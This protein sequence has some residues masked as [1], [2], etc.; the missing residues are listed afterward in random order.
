MWGKV[1]GDVF[2]QV[3]DGL[4]KSNLKWMILRNYEGLPYENRSKDVDI[5][6]PKKNFKIA[7]KIIDEVLKKNGFNKKILT[8]YPYAWCTTY[9][10]VEDDSTQSI[11]IDIV[12]GFIWKGVQIFSA[13]GL[14]ANSEVY[15]DFRIPNKVDD[16]IGLFIKPYLTGAFIKD[17]YKED[18]INI[19][20]NN[21]IEFMEQMLCILD[22]S[23]ILEII[24]L[25]KNGEIE[26]TLEIRKSV[27]TNILRRSLIN[28]P[29]KTS[30][31]CITH[32]TQELYRRRKIAK[33]SLIC[34][35]GPD[36][37]GK[38]TF[39]ELL[40]KKSVEIFNK[41]LDGIKVYHFR[42]NIIPNLGK[43]MENIG[44]GK[45]DTNFENPHRGTPKGFISSFIRIIYYWIDYVIGYWA[46]I[47]KKC[48]I[49]YKIIFD[50]YF[51]DFI[52]DP[53]RSSIKLPLWIRMILLNVT[54]QP[55]IV[56]ILSCNEDIIYK[57]KQELSIKKIRILLNRYN[58]LAKT[59]NRFVT[60][61]AT[62]TPSGLTNEALKIWIERSSTDNE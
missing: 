11:T 30:F 6:I 50:R 12:D 37:V 58:N 16:A 34:V 5:L 52:V 13:D 27:C 60:L 39:I 14:Y 38:S 55:S 9:F 61:D 36:G 2:Q 49:G 1:Q 53:E 43:T 10:R 57:R 18:I 23:I 47:R 19:V 35:L 40:H 54:P 31:N 48:N 3:I 15:R 17:K 59:S 8:K 41:E 32:Y 20:N 33:G 24:Q 25:I 51:Y 22:K 26:K 45:Q 21:E 44:V 56:F 4:N 62:Q 29:I 28:H 7:N 42:P 46:I